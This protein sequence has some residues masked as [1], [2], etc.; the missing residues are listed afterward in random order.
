MARR[1]GHFAG[2]PLYRGGTVVDSPI[3]RRRRR[4]GGLLG[5]PRRHGIGIANCRVVLWRRFVLPSC[6]FLPRRFLARGTR[7]VLA[8]LIQP[9]AGFLQVG[10]E[11]ERQLSQR[12]LCQPLQVGFVKLLEERGSG[13]SI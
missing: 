13:L 10:Q 2:T 11:F 4:M 9:F 6:A 12:R 1:A 7:T 3:R 8:V 5:F